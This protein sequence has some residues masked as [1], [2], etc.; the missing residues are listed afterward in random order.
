MSSSLAFISTPTNL[1]IVGFITLFVFIILPIMFITFNNYGVSS[2]QVKIL[3]DRYDQLPSK[4]PVSDL[5]ANLSKL[6]RF[7][8]MPLSEQCFVNFYSLACRFSGFIGPMDEGYWDPET[9][10][11]LAVK[12][13][14]AHL[15]LKLTTWMSA[16]AIPFHII[17]V[18][19]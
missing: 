11:R 1:F 16:W 9:S 8:P 5:L 17:L 7:D 19:Q 4:K 12:Q 10:I 15:F 14:V 13:G 18:L 3:S 2:E 6:P